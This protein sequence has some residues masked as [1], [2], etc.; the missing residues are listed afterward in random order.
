MAF[1]WSYFH[2]E[3]KEIGESSHPSV[4]KEKAKAFA[5]AFIKRQKWNKKDVTIK[6]TTEPYPYSERHEF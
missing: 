2:K 4:T 3:T 6:I 1:Y 5:V